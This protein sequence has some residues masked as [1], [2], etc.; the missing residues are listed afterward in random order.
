MNAR[1]TRLILQTLPNLNKMRADSGFI[2]IKLYYEKP[3][4]NNLKKKLK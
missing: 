3:Y 4:S 1:Y 2:L